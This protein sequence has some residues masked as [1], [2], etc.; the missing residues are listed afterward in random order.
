MS[1]HNLFLSHS[2]KYGDEYDRLIKLLDDQVSKNKDFDYTNFSVPK[3]DP[4]HDADNDAQLK[5]AIRAQMHKCAN[6]IVLAGVYS[7]YSKWIKIEIELAKEMNKKIIAI[8]PCGAE[9]TSEFVKN[10]ATHIISWNGLSVVNAIK[11][12][13]IT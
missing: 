12:L 4:V 9:R 8:Q 6:I 3:D 5:A 2:W 10:N 13:K 7:T 11:A 1:H